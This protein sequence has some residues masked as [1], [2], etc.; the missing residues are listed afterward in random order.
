MIAWLVTI[1]EFLA[2]WNR[3]CPRQDQPLVVLDAAALA[4]DL[5]HHSAR[6][7]EDRLRYWS[8]L[9]LDA[10]YA[11]DPMGEGVPPDTDPP[12]EVCAFDCETYVELVLA[13]AFARTPSEVTGWLDR[14]RHI[15]GR[16][17]IS[18]RFYTMAL[19][20]IPGNE[21]LG[22]LR[23]EPLRPFSVVRRPV[24]AKGRWYPPHRARFDLLGD[25]APSGTA[26]V[27]YNNLDTLLQQQARIPTPSL[28]FIVG[29]PMP[30][31]PFLIM[32]MGFILQGP[33][34]RKMFRHASRTVGRQRVEERELGDY[35]RSL[36]RFFNEPSSPRRTVLGLSLYRIL[37]PP[38]TPGGVTP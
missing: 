22:Y 12:I 32:H 27:R 30:G 4:D 3:A 15:D 24:S 29:A 14:M 1:L 38:R 11:I 26:E 20:W 17:T 6:P 36:R 8:G 35:L 13:L 37:E 31:N 34:G 25:N 9:F 18:H 5:A 28:A 10:P 19:H 7:L 23:E 33:D 21:K 16:R 2:P